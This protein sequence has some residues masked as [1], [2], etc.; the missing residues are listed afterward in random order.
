MDKI[1]V[2]IV[3]DHAIVR[4][5]LATLL[6]AKGGVEVVGEAD[7]G[8]TAVREVLRLKPDIVV[9]DIMMPVK[10]GITATR[11]ILATMPETKILILTT[12]TV[13]TDLSAAQQ[14]GAL[15]LIAKSADNAALVHAIRTVAAGKAVISPEIADLIDMS[16]SL[17]GLT[18]RQLEIL[19]HVSRGLSNPDIA[20]ILG[21]SVIT[22]K[23]H[24]ESILMKLG[25]AN[26]SEALTIALRLGILKI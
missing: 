16:Q 7:N 13:S 22:V 8:E 12:S 1:T 9:M 6:E 15:G 14:A 21:V 20:T 25:A 5:G 10:D 4:T 18:E 3:D 2:L 19:A 11:E 26:R 17:P 23:K 24:M